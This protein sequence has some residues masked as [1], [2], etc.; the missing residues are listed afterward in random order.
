MREKPKKVWVV[1]GGGGIIILDMRLRQ[2]KLVGAFRQGSENIR[3][4]VVYGIGRGLSNAYTIPF[5]I[6]HIHYLSG[7]LLLLSPFP[8]ASQLHVYMQNLK[9]NV[10]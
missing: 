2:S 8:Y 7:C 1:G 10:T 6:H 4:D 5:R 9:C 3:L